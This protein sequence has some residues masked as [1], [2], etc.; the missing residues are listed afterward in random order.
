[1]LVEE[2]EGD[3]LK[4]SG[5]SSCRSCG[6]GIAWLRRD[7]QWWPLDRLPDSRYQ[8]HDCPSRKRPQYHAPSLT[9]SDI[10]ALTSC[11]TCASERTKPCVGTRGKV[12][13][14][15]HAERMHEAQRIDS[16]VRANGHA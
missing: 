14:A 11:P 1:M 13:T 10:I 3:E 15:V 6:A 8:L 9:R 4:D 5:L 16:E 7:D 2:R 12:R